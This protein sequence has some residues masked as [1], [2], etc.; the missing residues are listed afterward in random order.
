MVSCDF[1][2]DEITDLAFECNYCDESYC[3]VHRL[4]ETHD[5]ANVAQ[6]VP[7]GSRKDEPEVFSNAPEATETE[8]FIDLADLKERADTEAQPYS[9]VE[10]TQTV[11]TKPEPDYDSS[12]D[13]AIDGSIEDEGLDQEENIQNE[14]ETDDLDNRTILFF[15]LILFGLLLGVILFGVV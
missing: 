4:P 11:G 3:Q 2:G 13:V 15:V 5:C 7:P 9:V 14:I 6:A 1:C 10:P 8:E 12:P